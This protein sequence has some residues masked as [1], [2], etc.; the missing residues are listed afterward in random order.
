MC[1]RSWTVRALLARV[2]IGTRRE[3]RVQLV[4]GVRG[5][6]VITAGQLKIRDGAAVTVVP[7]QEPK[8]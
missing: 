5:E 3:G 4:D 2:S 1:S 8:A 7:A 6:L